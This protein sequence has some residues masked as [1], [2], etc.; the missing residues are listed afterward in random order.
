MLSAKLVACCLCRLSQAREA[1]Q[2][3]ARGT[4]QQVQ[5]VLARLAGQQGVSQQVDDSQHSAEGD[6]VFAG[7]EEEV[8]QVSLIML[9][10]L[11]AIALLYTRHY[12]LS[13][14]MLSTCLLSN[15]FQIEGCLAGLDVDAM[16]CMLT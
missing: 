16:V 2:Q 8:P 13:T 9:P 3:L 6:E 4:V 11:F 5:P 15:C 7:E 14:Y 1:A 12:S 10:P